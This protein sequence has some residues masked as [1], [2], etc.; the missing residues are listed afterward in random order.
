MGKTGNIRMSK[1]TIY[2]YI[3]EKNK[4]SH[5]CLPMFWAYFHVYDH[6]FKHLFLCCNIYPLNDSL[7][8]FPLMYRQPNLTLLVNGSR[9]NSVELESLVRHTTFQEHRTFGSEL[10]FVIYGHGS[11]LDHV[12]KTILTK[13]TFLLSKRAPHKVWP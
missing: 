11:H 12:S 8:V 2:I 13:F 4:F 9:S 1:L 5:G 7:T 6:Y 3:F 10:D